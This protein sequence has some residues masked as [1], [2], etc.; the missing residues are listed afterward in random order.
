LI[1]RP[2]IVAAS[3]LVAGTMVGEYQITHK[4]GEGGMGVV[5]AGVHPEIGK[6]VAIKILGPKA[7]AYPDLIR[8]FKE[9]AR[10][11]NKIRHPNIIDIFAFNQLRDGRHYFVMEYLEGESLTDRLAR[12]PMDFGEMRRLLE[13][14]CSALHAAH[15]AGVVHRDLKP[16]NIWVATQTMSESRIKLLDFGI[17]KLNDISV[18]SATQ[19]GVPMG[20]PLYMPPEQGLGRAVDR[21]A[22]VYALGVLLYQVFAGTLPFQ[23]ASGYEIVLKHVT[24]AP[25]PPSRHRPVWPKEMEAIILDCLEKDPS[26][27]PAS[28]KVLLDRIEAAFIAHAKTPVSAGSV[29]TVPRLTTPPPP[30]AAG[31]PVQMPSQLPSWVKNL[32]TA[33]PEGQVIGEVG[34]GST[35]GD[36]RRKGALVMA[37]VVLIAGSATAVLLVPRSWTPSAAV[38][39]RPVQVAPPTAGPGKGVTVL[40]AA[41]R[42][43]KID[44]DSDP[45]GAHVVSRVDGR[46]LGD[47]PLSLERPRSDAPLEVRLELEGFKSRDLTVPLVSDFASSYELAKH[48]R[49]R[50]AQS[51]P[52][53]RTQVTAT[54]ASSVVP[55]P[56]VVAAPIV[57][58]PPQ[59]V[60]VPATPK[61]ESTSDIIKWRVH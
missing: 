55:P 29:S 60:D 48:S 50:T 58:S 56:P 46:L 35:A 32:P 26:K 41:L 4:L 23:G 14:I 8:R 47:T 61:K 17:A 33:V 9:E 18:A 38:V 54:P 22:D 49:A 25:V 40:P 16:D 11:V 21:R 2:D 12:G 6:R 7:A 42:S 37:A 27:R 39:E 44:I 53:G 20:T 59:P 30:P 31:A 24:E 1:E 36:R 5:Y 52:S 34:E 19:S 28:A 57:P 51:R 3:E 13:Q 15:E 45:G 10:A 43:V